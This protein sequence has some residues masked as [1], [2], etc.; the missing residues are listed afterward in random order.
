[1]NNKIGLVKN[2]K[3]CLRSLKIMCKIMLGLYCLDLKFKSWVKVSYIQ[4]S[5]VQAF[6]PKW[7]FW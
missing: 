5:G 6:K 4:C 2:P 3:K 1:M 7:T